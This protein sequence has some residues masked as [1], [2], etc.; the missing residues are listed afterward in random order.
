MGSKGDYHIE[1]FIRETMDD[2]KGLITG[3][4]YNRYSYRSYSIN[5]ED[6]ILRRIFESQGIGFYVDVGAFHPFIGSNT[7][8]FYIRGWRG[9]NIEP[10][11]GS[12]RIFDK[13]RPRDINL[14]IAVAESEGELTYFM[15]DDPALNTFNE[16]A[17][18]RLLN[19]SQYSLLNKVKIKA[20]PLWQILDEYLPKGQEIDFLN[21]DAEGYDFLV[22]KSFDF[23][24]YKP[25]VIL[26]EIWGCELDDLFK[27][28]VYIYLKEKGYRLFAKTS[29]TF[30]FI[31][32][33]V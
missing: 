33:G 17:A 28:E 25:K 24:R 22:L 18:L 19:K 20:K 11:P 1:V 10:R 8:F 32:D 9:I 7:Y 12:K 31:K 13:Y 23:E 27:N 2:F 5:G 30:I 16:E 6:M 21:I 29:D 3:N 4:M 14:E 26:I 15:F